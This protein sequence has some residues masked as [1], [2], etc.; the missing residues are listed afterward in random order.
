MRL[1]Q[2]TPRTPDGL[3]SNQTMAAVINARDVF[4][5]LKQANT[6]TIPLQ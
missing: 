2:I 3:S 5:T 1:A 6:V 4:N